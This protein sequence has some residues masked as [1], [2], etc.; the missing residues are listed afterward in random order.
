MLCN[1]CQNSLANTLTLSTHGRRTLTVLDSQWSYYIE[2]SFINV[3]ECSWHF[4]WVC[5]IAEGSCFICNFAVVIVVKMLLKCDEAFSRAVFMKN[6]CVNNTQVLLYCAC[7]KSRWTAW[8]TTCWH[9][10]Q[11]NSINW[12]RTV[13]AMLSSLH[14]FVLVVCLTTW[15]YLYS[16]LLSRT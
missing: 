2:P 3:F 16:V 6:S 1:S 4:F 14:Q 15:R 9:R 5:T 7:A 11:Q 13:N 10:W 12:S 8:I